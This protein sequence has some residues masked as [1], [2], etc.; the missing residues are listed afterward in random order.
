LPD[1]Y[2][3][4]DVL[5][6]PASPARELMERRLDWRLIYSDPDALLFARAN[7]AAARISGSILP[8]QIA[9]TRADFERII[10]NVLKWRDWMVKRN[11]F[12]LPVPRM[13]GPE[14]VSI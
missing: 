2:P 14:F 7:S 5:I 3:H 11:G 10:R 8:S 4:H 13:G 12:E 9:R 6:T 1:A